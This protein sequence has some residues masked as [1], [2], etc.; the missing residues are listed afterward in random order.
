MSSKRK[1]PPTKLDGSN[2]ITDSK[3]TSHDDVAVAPSAEINLS[4]RSSPHLADTDA[5]ND[6]KISTENCHLEP[7]SEMTNRHNQLNGE[8]MSGKTKRRGGDIQVREIV[9]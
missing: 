6:R 5:H 4:I 8:R 3:L 9:V 2:G 7:N 1:S